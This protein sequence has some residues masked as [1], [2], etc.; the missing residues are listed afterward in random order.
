L[1]PNTFIF[2]GQNKGIYTIPLS[3]KGIRPIPLFSWVK[4]KV[5]LLIVPQRISSKQ[6]GQEKIIRFPLVLF[7]CCLL[8]VVSCLEP[9]N[10]Q[11]TTNN[12][13]Q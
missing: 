2:V 1:Y 7:A 9:N 5:F 11:Q 13:Q 6:K 3:D 12:Y 4:I 8:L 10:Q